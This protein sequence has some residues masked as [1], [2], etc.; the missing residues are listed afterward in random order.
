METGVLLYLPHYFH[1]PEES[2][3]KTLQQEFVIRDVCI[4]TMETGVL[5]YLLHYFHTPAESRRDITT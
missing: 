4:K 1:T 3:E 5:L 2:H